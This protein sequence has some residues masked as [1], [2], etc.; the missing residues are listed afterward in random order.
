MIDLSIKLNL[1]TIILFEPLYICATDLT[2]ATD[3]QSLFMYK[4]I[5]KKIKRTTSLRFHIESLR[6]KKHF[7]INR[8]KQGQKQNNA[9]Q[10]KYSIRKKN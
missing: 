7:F 3:L 2:T 4:L 8:E 5:N 6:K 1:W 10:I 9:P